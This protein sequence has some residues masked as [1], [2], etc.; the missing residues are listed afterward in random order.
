[1]AGVFG[2]VDP[3]DVAGLVD[4]E[5]RRV[6]DVDAVVTAGLVADADGVEERALFVGQEREAALQALLQPA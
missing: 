5:S 1:M 4:E 3:L 6:G 2:L